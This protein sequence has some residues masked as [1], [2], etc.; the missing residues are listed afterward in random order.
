MASLARALKKDID[1][2]YSAVKDAKRPRIHLFLATSD[3]HLE[4]K[5]KISKEQ[6][7]LRI[8]QNVSYA[9]SLC[10]DIEFS[11]EDA[12]RT[13]LDFLCQAVEIAIREGATTVNLPD[14]VGYMTP[15]EIA[16][17]VTYVKTHVKNIDQA[18]ISMQIGRASCRER[19]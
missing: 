9:K 6:A 19:V 14:T 5:L 1:C 2:A 7:L 12:T 10:S 11:C 13:D 15:L 8:A 18:V 4:Y 16:N 3:L 17:M